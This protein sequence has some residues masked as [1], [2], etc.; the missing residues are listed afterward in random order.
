MEQD[1]LKWIPGEMNKHEPFQQ[2]NCS[3]LMHY[4]QFDGVQL[5]QN[6]MKLAGEALESVS[7]VTQFPY[8]CT[9]LPIG[10]AILL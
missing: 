3:T 8:L 7:N 5:L 10:A 4:Y 6:V 2:S 9:G 1:A